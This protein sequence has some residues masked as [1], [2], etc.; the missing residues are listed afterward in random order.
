MMDSAEMIAQLP[1]FFEEYCSAVDTEWL[2]EPP[3]GVHGGAWKFRVSDADGALLLLKFLGN[4]TEELRVNVGL[5]IE[6]DYTAELAAFVNSLNFKQL[7]HG[8]MFVI[9]GVPFVSNTPGRCAV[10][11]QEI[12][13]GGRHLSMGSVPTM[14]HLLDVAGRLAGQGTRFAP[15]IVERFGGRPFGEDDESYGALM[16]F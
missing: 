11:M 2:L 4:D 13:F 7:I 6:L 16:A 3:P 12:F 5:V 14:N 1:R 15:E 9:G 10:V 8:R